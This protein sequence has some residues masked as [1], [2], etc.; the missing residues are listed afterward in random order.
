MQ[1]VQYTSYY[2][3]GTDMSK[4]LACGWRHNSRKLIAIQLNIQNSSGLRKWT[5]SIHSVSKMKYSNTNR[6]FTQLTIWSRGRSRPSTRR[7]RAV[8]TR[9]KMEAVSISETSLI[10]TRLH[11]A[12]SQQTVI[13]YLSLIPYSF[14]MGL[15]GRLDLPCGWLTVYKEHCMYGIWDR[16]TS[17]R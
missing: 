12:T 13:F 11:G 3:T 17:S 2:G 7:M 5:T 10:S 6:M 16:L 15:N 14:N 1:R 4:N 9:A 8:A